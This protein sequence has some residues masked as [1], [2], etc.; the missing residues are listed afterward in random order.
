[1]STLSLSDFDSTNGASSVNDM[2]CNGPDVSQMSHNDLRMYLKSIGVINSFPGA[3]HTF[4][5]QLARMHKAQK[6][7]LKFYT[8]PTVAE[9][10]QMRYDMQWEGVTLAMLGTLVSDEMSS[11]RSG[12]SRFTN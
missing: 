12:V 8:K 5:V 3:T 1:M 7:P 11:R 4:L 9:L 2:E 6:L 10:L